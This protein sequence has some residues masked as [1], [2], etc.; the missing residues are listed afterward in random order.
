MIGKISSN[1]SSMSRFIVVAQ[2]ENQFTKKAVFYVG[3]VDKAV[4]V[5][6]MHAFVSGLFVEILSLFVAKPR[7]PRRFASSNTSVNSTTAFRLRLNKDHCDRLLDDTKWRAFISVS[8]WSFKPPVP[9]TPI[10]QTGTK[11]ETRCCC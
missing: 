4:T 3:N 5:D 7:Q 1:D 10:T 8:E 11:L 2:R 6:Q 9:P